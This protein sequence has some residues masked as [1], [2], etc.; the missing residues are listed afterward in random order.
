MQTYFLN[1]SESPVTESTQTDGSDLERMRTQTSPVKNYYRTVP[2]DDYGITDNE[3][4]RFAPV[5]S[6]NLIE[7]SDHGNQVLTESMVVHASEQSDDSVSHNPEKDYKVKTLS[8]GSYFNL[9]NLG[10]NEDN[11]RAIGIRKLTPNGH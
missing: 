8:N 2:L 4:P 6:L 11:G 10:D 1:S 9:H 5:P 7:D 3:T